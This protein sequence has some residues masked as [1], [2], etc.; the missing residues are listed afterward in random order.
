MRKFDSA[1]ALVPTGQTTVVI[2]IGTSSLLRDEKHSLNLL[3]LA[4][5]VETIRDLKDQGEAANWAIALRL[6]C[7][8]AHLLPA[9]GSCAPGSAGQAFLQCLLCV[10]PSI[11]TRDKVQ[12]AQ[13]RPAPPA[14]HRHECHPGQQRRG[15]RGVPAHGA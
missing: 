15:G 4:G 10:A 11:P 12:H 13:A 9:A 1:A 8:P 5:I 3:S 7:A 6:S 14:C 2:K